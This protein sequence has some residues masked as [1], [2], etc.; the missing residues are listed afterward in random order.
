MFFS[1]SFL[2]L[3]FFMQW[4]FCMFWRHCEAWPPFQHRQVVCPAGGFHVIVI[5]GVGANL[6]SSGAHTLGE[7]W[8]FR[9][10]LTGTHQSETECYN[11][12]LHAWHASLMKMI[13][14]LGQFKIWII[15]FILAL[16]PRVW[17]KFLHF[18]HMR[19]R[20]YMILSFLFFTG[21]L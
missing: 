19:G 15:I 13:Q 14:C 1:F 4:S 18:F 9:H 21:T 10:Y 5:A 3:P 7:Q 16:D 6:H 20:E 2:F 11:G 17:G 8:K 12:V